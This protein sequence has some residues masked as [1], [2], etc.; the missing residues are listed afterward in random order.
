M[1]SN[2][3]LFLAFLP[4]IIFM[5]SFASSLNAKTITEEEIKAKFILN[6][7]RFTEFPD[8]DQ[9]LTVC[10]ISDDV[11]LSF[12]EE[13]T[14]R[15]KLKYDIDIISKSPR[16]EFDECHILYISDEYKSDASFIIDKTSGRAILTISDISN[17]SLL[18]GIVTFQFE[19]DIPKIIVNITSLRESS[20]VISSNLLS[21]VEIIE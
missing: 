19:Y 14:N 3:L 16:D 4:V 13:Q 2:Q 18:R 17:F 7:D 9:M 1:K 6:F 10:L 21:I 20:L 11:T 12:L 15:S 5:L 8:V